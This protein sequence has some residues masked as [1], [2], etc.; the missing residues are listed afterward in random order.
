MK[1]FWLIIGL[2]ILS[3]CKSNL[4]YGVIYDFENKHPISGVEIDDYLNSTKTVS[5]NNGHFSLAHVGR[6]SGKLIFKKAG[7]ITDTLETISS[8]SGEQFTEGFKGDT[9]YLFTTTSNFRDS[10]DRLNSVPVAA[11]AAN[12][13]KFTGDW[14]YQSQVT[15]E[16]SIVFKLHLKTKGS[17]ISG[18]YCAVE[19]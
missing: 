12:I 6:I 13:T 5:D 7:Y 10:I 11:T 4:Y 2:L 16:T 14:S 9:V 19:N 1:S 15:D 3:G 18:S 8:K 17:S